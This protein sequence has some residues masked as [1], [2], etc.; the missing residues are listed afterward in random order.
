M[1]NV[2]DV[3]Q[4]ADSNMNLTKGMTKRSGVSRFNDESQDAEYD[5]DFEEDPTGQNFGQTSSQRNSP[6]F[7][8]KY[9]RSNYSHSNQNRSPSNRMSNR[10]ATEQAGLRA[11]VMTRTTGE[12]DSS[13]MQNTAR[14]SCSLVTVNSVVTNPQLQQNTGSRQS[15]TKGM[16]SR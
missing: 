13:N 4:N 9:Y 14:S 5:D 10:S 6:N 11:A 2:E 12:K 15:K 3:S 8:Q 1:L 7:H 16:M